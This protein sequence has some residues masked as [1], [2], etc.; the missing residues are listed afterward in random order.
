MPLLEF[1][2]TNPFTFWSPS[3]L[4]NLYIFSLIILV[5]L[6]FSLA[7]WFIILYLRR[8]YGERKVPKEWSVFWWA[9]FF[10]ALH[11]I[12]EFVG[13]YQWIL[14]KAFFVFLSGVEITSVVLLTW[15]CYL[16]VKTYVL[17]K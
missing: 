10:F 3:F 4:Q 16:L 6:L 2:A 15:G 17:K 7:A 13:L 11:E 8:F 9:L 5:T 12:L 14:G 1:H